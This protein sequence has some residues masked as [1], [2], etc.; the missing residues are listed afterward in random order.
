MWQR[1]TRSRNSA[2][3]STFII[4]IK[5]NW[6]TGAWYT[7]PLIARKRILIEL[8][9]FDMELRML[10]Y[11]LLK[12]GYMYLVKVRFLKQIPKKQQGGLHSE[13][14]A[15]T[16][17]TSLRTPSSPP[18]IRRAKSIKCIKMNGKYLHRVRFYFYNSFSIRYKNIALFFLS[19]E[20]HTFA[21][22][23]RRC[24]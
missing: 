8:M 3:S 13:S 23:F 6:K 21:L 11:N 19:I 15:W 2:W 22:L 5:M 7:K 16:S 20:W 14:G 9:V 12:N 1:T 18:W 24:R 10:F 17:T 4:T